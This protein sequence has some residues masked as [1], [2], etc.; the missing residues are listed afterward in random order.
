M[1]FKDPHVRELENKSP[2]K[3]VAFDEEYTDFCIS[4]KAN[5]LYITKNKNME[6]VCDLSTAKIFGKH[7][8]QN[9]MCAVSIA[10]ILD[11]DNDVIQKCTNERF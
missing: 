8:H 7:N 3:I 1:N 2:S 11:V 5:K 10:K 9:I 6:K 4:E